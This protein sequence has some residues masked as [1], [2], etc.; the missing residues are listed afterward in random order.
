MSDVDDRP[1]SGRVS[2]TS[3]ISTAVVKLLRQYTGR[4]PVKARTII[5]R[6]VVAVVL[7]ETMT[8]AE[9]TLSDTGDADLVLHLRGQLQNTMREDL[10]AI[11]ESQTQRKVIAF[12]S[13]NH[14]EPDMAAEVFVLEAEARQP[15]EVEASDSSA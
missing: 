3:A 6:D 2:V 5:D 4:G 15:T 7:G 10:V 1:D 12:M 13:A 11:A 14:I 8:K 9:R